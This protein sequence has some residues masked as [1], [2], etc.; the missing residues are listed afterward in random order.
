MPPADRRWRDN[1]CGRK[2]GQ[3]APQSPSRFEAP[4]GGPSHT[5][6]EHPQIQRWAPGFAIYR[7]PSVRG[8]GP[9]SGSRV[10]G[11]LP[12]GSKGP[13]VGRRRAI[14]EREDNPAH[15]RQLSS[16]RPAGRRLLRRQN[17]CF[18]AVRWVSVEYG[19]RPAV[20]PSVRRRSPKFALTAVI[21]EGRSRVKEL[22]RR[23]SEERGG[24]SSLRHA[25]AVVED[26]VIYSSGELMVWFGPGGS[27]KLAPVS[28]GHD[29]KRARLD[30]RG[31]VDRVAPAP[32]LAAEGVVGE[33]EQPAGD[34]DAGDLVA[35]P[36]IWPKPERNRI[37]DHYRLPFPGVTIELL[38]VAPCPMRV[39][40]VIRPLR[41]A[42][43]RARR[44]VRFAAAAARA[45]PGLRGGR[46]GCWP[47]LQWRA[48]QGRRLC[49]ACRGPSCG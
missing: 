49:G 15:I 38:A 39:A 9:R 23:E 12:A 21:N 36:A 42:G 19:N 6:L 45:V 30:H 22:V 26:R 16:C 40:P 31:W 43:W 3:I 41:A 37:F 4:R 27:I 48:R 5:Q 17:H 8:I 25:D 33:S 2:S 46:P 35:P 18:A 28:G 34:R 10:H 11:G 20:G 29:S 44:R 47:W 24:W 7:G 14:S 32:V 13:A 1:R